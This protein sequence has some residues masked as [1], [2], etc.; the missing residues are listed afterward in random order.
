GDVG[1]LEAGLQ[2]GVGALDDALE[3]AGGEVFLQLGE[4]RPLLRGGGGERGAGEEQE[5][6]RR[7]ADHFV[8][9]TVTRV[10]SP[11]TAVTLRA[12]VAKPG[13]RNTSSCSPGGNLNVNGV[14]PFRM[15][16]T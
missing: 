8:S 16:S 3:V 15:P 11:A 7:E 10:T 4:R 9:S 1:R 13:R 12:C 6:E 5:A 2:R 14:V